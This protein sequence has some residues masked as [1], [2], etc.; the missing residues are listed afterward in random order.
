MKWFYSIFIVFF[1]GC[2]SNEE[3]VNQSAQFWYEQIIIALAD[4]NLQKADSYFNSLQSEH[5]ASPFI[6]EALL[7]LA[8]YHMAENEHLLAGFFSEEYK[9]RF[10]STQN[11]NYVE[12]LGLEAGYYA[13][14]N[15][16]KDHGYINDNISNIESFIS[17]NKNNEYLPYIRHMLT[18]FK[19][20]QLELNNEIKRVYKVKDK[21]AA[22]EAYN[23]KNIA[24]G[25]E[26]IEFRKS[27]IPWWVQAFSW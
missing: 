16:T 23:K 18:S 3:L 26:N 13:F 2:A 24:L 10:S 1:I 22:Q 20:A 5:T 17:L 12:F 15:Y 25:V 7:M 8:K 21:A 9:I 19:L 11:V 14:G 27:R 4:G 6:K